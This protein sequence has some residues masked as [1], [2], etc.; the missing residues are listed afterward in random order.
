MSGRVASWGFAPAVLALALVFAWCTCPSVAFAASADD[1]HADLTSSPFGC[2]TCHLSA[3]AIYA[4]IGTPDPSVDPTS[5]ATCVRCHVLPDGEGPRVYDGDE[6]HYRTA[7]GF[8]HN[9]PSK[10]SCLKCHSIHGPHVESPALS[11]KLLRQL[12]Y[13]SEA[14]AAV[15]LA[16]APHD[17]ALSVWC[18]GC[19]AQWP[20][21]PVEGA[22][23]DMPLNALSGTSLGHP[24]GPKD[25][26]RA[27]NDCTTCLSC[28]AA[29]G[30]FPHYTAGADAGL[31]GAASASE[32]RVGVAQRYSDAVC[33]GCHRYSDADGLEGVGMSY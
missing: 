24:F 19:H 28:H 26:D 25:L 12:D 29:P 10:V 15:D 32:Q 7:D 27:W 9:D 33:L 30:G 2:P 3:A 1:P 31:V 11:G 13:Q 6:A 21:A 4:V 5:D 20:G 22:A 23:D 14:L 17:V 8:G 16:T 18:T